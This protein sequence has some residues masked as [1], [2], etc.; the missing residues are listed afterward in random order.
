MDKIIVRHPKVFKII[1]NICIIAFIYSCCIS[2]TYADVGNSVDYN[3]G[4]TNYGNGSYGGNSSYSSSFDFYTIYWLMRFIFNQPAIIIV[5]LV[6]AVVVY[7]LGKNKQQ[8]SRMAMPVNNQY[9]MV[10]NKH[11]E[12][13]KILLQKDPEFS[14]QM[15]VGKVNNMFMR[16]Q[17]AWMDKKWEEVR[18]FETDALFNT[19]KMQLDQYIANK[20][21]NKIEDIAIVDTEVLKYEA[22]GEF[23]YLDVSIKAKFV[24]YI[25]DDV[26][27]KVIKGDK[28]KTI[29]MHYKWKMMRKIGTKTK[30]SH[31]E[32]IACPNCGANL[33]I[34]QAGRC[35]YCDS[36]VTKG[37]FDWLLSEI[38]V[39]SQN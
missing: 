25:V 2:H 31:V 17:L 5:I 1:L 37:D 36:I 18:P 21:T 27:N 26:T 14:E 39:I 33:S 3:A 29:Y 35:E 12:S 4:N 8:N 22:I 7:L 6:I 34:N 20:R 9:G 10:M 19:H 13:I 23:E 16:L 11:N 32:A 30:N 15:M 28:N 38:E 24:D